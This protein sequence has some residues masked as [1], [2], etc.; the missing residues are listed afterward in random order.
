MAYT[1]SSGKTI[2][3]GKQISQ[4]GEGAVHEVAGSGN[5][6]AKICERLPG[7]THFGEKLVFMVNNIDQELLA[8]AAWPK[9]LL[10]RDGQLCGFIMPRFKNARELHLFTDARDR[11]TY[12]PGRDGFAFAVHV[13]QCVAIAF[14]HVH[15]FGYVV[16]DV[17]LRN[18]LLDEAGTVRIIDCDSFQVTTPQ[19]VVYPCLVGVPDFKAPELY[20]HLSGAPRTIAQ[21]NFAMAIILFKLLLDDNHPFAGKPPQNR[22]MTLEEKIQQNLYAYSRAS[23][24]QLMPPNVRHPEDVLPPEMVDLFERAFTQAPAQRPDA[25]TWYKALVRLEQGL[26]KQKAGAKQPQQPQPPATG[27]FCQL[28][29][30]SLKGRLGRLR[31]MLWSVSATLILGVLA[32]LL[33]VL[34]DNEMAR[35]ISLCVAFLINVIFSFTVSSQRLHDM[36]RS[37]SLIL[38]YVLLLCVLSFIAVAGIIS[39]N[40]VFGYAVSV[41]IFLAAFPGDAGANSYGLPPPPHNPR[42]IVA[43]WVCI[44]IYVVIV[45]ASVFF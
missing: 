10:Y 40:W 35:G 26:Q 8:H 29:F 15:R 38:G 14:H 42:T 27:N 12:F 6:L 1:D 45:V 13:A 39:K 17:Q 4:G 11:Q 34:I 23:K 21:D 30:F 20:D 31:F 3:L 37:S 43:A 2:R 25:G 28:K 33:A 32:G 41:K 24:R 9:T 36:N 44:F 22:D 19:G 5:V 18:I 16:G 7:D